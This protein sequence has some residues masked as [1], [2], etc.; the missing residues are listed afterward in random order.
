MQ[1]HADRIDLRG[2][3]FRHRTDPGHQVR[4]ESLG[5]AVSCHGLYIDLHDRSADPYVLRSLLRDAHLELAISNFHVPD[6]PSAT[7]CGYERP[8]TFLLG[9]SGLLLRA[10]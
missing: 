10:N 6:D 9:K 8:K 7:G 1:R 4:D 5:V 2:A 3:N